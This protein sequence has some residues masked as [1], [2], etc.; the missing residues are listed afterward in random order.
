MIAAGCPLP[1]LSTSDA[2][3]PGVAF[4]SASGVL[5]GTAD[6]AAEGVVGITFTASN[7]VGDDAQQA[8]TLSIVVGDRVFSDG[9]E[10]P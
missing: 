8:F 1:S 6:G 7:G 4:D 9:F 5:N 3:P 2:L 10:I